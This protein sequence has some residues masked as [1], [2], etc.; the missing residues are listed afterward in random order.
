[1][2]P[3]EHG[4]CIANADGTGIRKL[5]D[6][7]FPRTLA[8]LRM[9]S[10]IAFRADCQLSLG[11]DKPRDRVGQGEDG[12]AY[13]SFDRVNARRGALRALLPNAV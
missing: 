4:L 2:P 9:G 8:G 6:S 12:Q 1:M 3:V 10:L 13:L 5:A 7:R 11:D